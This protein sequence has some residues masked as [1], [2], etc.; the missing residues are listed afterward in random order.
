MQCLILA[1]PLLVESL[2][3]PCVR[4]SPAH[5]FVSYLPPD[6]LYAHGKPL[7][8]VQILSCLISIRDRSSVHLRARRTDSEGIGLLSLSSTR[9]VARMRSWTR[10]PRR[11]SGPTR[12]LRW[13]DGTHPL[14]RQVPARHRPRHLCHER[15]NTIFSLFSMKVVPVKTSAESVTWMEW[16]ADPGTCLQMARMAGGKASSPGVQ[17][18]QTY[19]ITSKAGVEGIGRTAERNAASG[20]RLS[21]RSRTEQSFSRLAT[22]AI[23]CQVKRWTEIFKLSPYHP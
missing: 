16:P 9:I 21:M 5:P 15:V 11:Y 13:L 10:V 18:D 1:K 2:V 3:L 7:P 17:G 22:W 6:A 4:L 8:V 12:W 20:D 23:I 14:T 19:L